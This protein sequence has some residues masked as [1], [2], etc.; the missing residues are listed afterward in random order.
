MKKILYYI[1]LALVFVVCAGVLY[2]APAMFFWSGTPNGIY[3]YILLSFVFSAFAYI[4]KFI[5][6]DLNFK[7]KKKNK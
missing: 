6:E 7:R 5:P 3:P 2:L 4:K 1:I